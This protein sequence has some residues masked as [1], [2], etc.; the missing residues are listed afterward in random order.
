MK[1]IKH[2]Y[3]LSGAVLSLCA[4]ALGSSQTLAQEN[5]ELWAIPG[6][7]PA[8]TTGV[9]INLE[10]LE[11]QW[12]SIVTEDWLWRMRVPDRGDFTS[13]PLNERGREVGMTW[14][15]SMIGSCL[16]YGAAGVMRQPTRIR[17]AW[18]G[19][20]R[21]ALETDN[22]AQTRHFYFN[23]RRPTDLGRSLQGFSIAE[24]QYDPLLGGGGFGAGGGGG[25][26]NQGPRHGQMKVVTTDLSAAW[27]RSN[28]APVSENAT[29]TEYFA[30]FEGPEGADWLL[31][32]SIV[33][34]PEYLNTEYVTSS[35]FR[36]ETDLSGWNPQPCR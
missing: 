30:I 23:Q 28:G 17:L 32:T 19:E 21:L 24:W 20:N 6:G 29:V 2:V 7:P 5:F 4:L 35:H 16:A 36:R 31:V 3:G 13:L 15:E 10:R 12:V 14:D 34:D 18:E 9:P 26:Q 8:S 22:G 1:T 27:L 33:H 25:Q 11:G